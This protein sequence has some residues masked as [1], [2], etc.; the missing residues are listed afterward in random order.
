LAQCSGGRR[1]GRRGVQ[2]HSRVPGR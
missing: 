2:L 1:R